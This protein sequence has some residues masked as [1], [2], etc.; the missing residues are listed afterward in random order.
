MGS[1]AGKEVRGSA[2]LL[3]WL[4]NNFT[5]VSCFKSISDLTYLSVSICTSCAP[6]APCS[7]EAETNFPSYLE[8]CIQSVIFPRSGRTNHQIIRFAQSGT[9]LHITSQCLWQFKLLLY[10]FHPTSHSPR[11][12][13][14]PLMWTEKYVTFL[15]F[16]WVTRHPSTFFLLPPL[17]SNLWENKKKI[18]I[19]K[20]NRSKKKGKKRMLPH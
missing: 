3:I 6:L 1:G 7:S 5:N 15:H 8:S 14:S 4:K 12:P 19:L 17:H 2:Q 10:F 11:K 18:Q 16:A 20:G 9:T 13:P